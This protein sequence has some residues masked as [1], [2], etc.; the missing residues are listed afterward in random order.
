MSMKNYNNNLNMVW[1][2]RIAS[3]L[4]RFKTI[5]SN[6]FTYI[7]LQKLKEDQYDHF[8]QQNLRRDYSDNS[9]I[10]IDFNNQKP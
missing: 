6:Q 3:K 4:F 9:Y 5:I 1:N 10:I 2:W 7:S 8:Y